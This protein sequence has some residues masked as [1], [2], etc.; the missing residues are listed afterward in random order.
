MLV[1]SSHADEELLTSILAATAHRLAVDAIASIIFS[2]GTERPFGALAASLAEH[3]LPSCLVYGREDPWVRKA[4]TTTHPWGLFILHCSCTRQARE[5][6]LVLSGCLATVLAA[7]QV[8]PLWGQR[9]KRLVPEAAYYEVRCP[10]GCN[11]RENWLSCH[12]LGENLLCK[13]SSNDYPR[14]QAFKGAC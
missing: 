4:P 12:Y 11:C 8:V 5:C 6:H 1:R 7:M 14:Q 9:L 10:R 3:G 13:G 2:P